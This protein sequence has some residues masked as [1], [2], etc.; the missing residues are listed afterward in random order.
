[1]VF[2]LFHQQAPREIVGLNFVSGQQNDDG[3][4]CRLT[5]ANYDIEIRPLTNAVLSRILLA[6][7]DR[8]LI[9]ESPT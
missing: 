1:M 8:Y 7:S 4:T 6:T 5:D 3:S 2:V 9:P